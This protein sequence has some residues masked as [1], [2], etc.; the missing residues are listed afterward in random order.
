MT[1]RDATPA[2][3]ALGGGHPRIGHPDDHVGAH[4]RLLSEQLAHPGTGAVKLLSVQAA[5]GTCEVYELEQAELGLYAL[6]RP[7]MEALAAVGAYHEHLAG[8]HL[9]HKV[10]AG[11]I[12]RRRLGGQDPPIVQFS[13]AQRPKTVRVPHAHQVRPV[14]E[15]E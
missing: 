4:R 8:L 10:G 6:S 15:D 14:S 7:G 5:V 9:P 11:D 12:E 3:I 2:G 13:E 1:K